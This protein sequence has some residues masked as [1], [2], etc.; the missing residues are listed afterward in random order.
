MNVIAWILCIAAII[1]ILLGE[2]HNLEL[3]F[4]NCNIIK[5]LKVNSFMDKYGLN[6]ASNLTNFSSINVVI[7]GNIYLF[8]IDTGSIDN[9]ITKEVAD[10]CKDI[11]KNLNKKTKLV[12]SSGSTITDSVSLS[13]RYQERNYKSNFLVSEPIEHSFSVVEEHT[14]IKYSGVLGNAFLKENNW[15]LDTKQNIIWIPSIN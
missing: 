1:L 10:R 4:K 15:I 9:I 6:P 3:N 11:C 8:F 13:F 14:G 5:K 2:L 12:G 7:G